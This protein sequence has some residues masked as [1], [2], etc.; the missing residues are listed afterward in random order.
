MEVS[1]CPDSNKVE[2]RIFFVDLTTCAMTS[3]TKVAG[4]LALMISWSLM[5][6]M[7]QTL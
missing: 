6:F 1:S 7:V 5:Q 2:K 4:V 3:V